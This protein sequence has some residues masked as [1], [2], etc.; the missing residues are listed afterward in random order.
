MTR[1][2]CR[3]DDTALLRKEYMSEPGTPRAAY[4]QPP[5]SDGLLLL[6]Q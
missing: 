4:V 2:V 3:A 6:A 5:P 1:V